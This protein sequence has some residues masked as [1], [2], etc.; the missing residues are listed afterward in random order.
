M[1]GINMKKEYKDVMFEVVE[2]LRQYGAW[3]EAHEDPK[4]NQKDHN[5]LVLPELD[6]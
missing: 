1:K 3:C 5:E 6:K 2:L 4:Q